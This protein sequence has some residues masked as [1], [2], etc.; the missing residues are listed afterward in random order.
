VPDRTPDLSSLETALKRAL[1]PVEPPRELELRLEQTLDSI[2]ELAAE[3]LEGWELTGLRDPR[4]WPR[5]TLGPAAAI[6]VGS[7][8]AVGLV[9]LRTQ[10][11]R[12]KRRSAS[13]G[14]V[15]LAGRTMRDFAREA[16]RVFDDLAPDR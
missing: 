8:A 2:V 9:V 3:E 13:R 6:V 10:R 7:G 16:L 1:A 14:A 15:D 4:N 5:A 11:R 12:H